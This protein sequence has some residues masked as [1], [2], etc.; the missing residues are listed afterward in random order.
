MR[1][2]ILGGVLGGGMPLRQDAIAKR[3]QV[4]QV[5]ARE[6]LRVLAEE[7]LVEVVPRK[8]A[9]VYSLT[10][11]EAAEITELRILLEGALLAAAIPN[12]TE[13]DL[14]AAEA[15]MHALDE[16]DGNAESLLRL[17]V[18]FHRALYSKAARP[19]TEAILERLRLNME[20]YLRL[21]W[22]RTGY[23]GKSQSE[24]AQILQLCRERR[25]EDVQ[26]VLRTHIESTG[27]EIQSL[28]E[29]NAKA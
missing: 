12:L 6:A 4:S 18:N 28:L 17:N 27:R 19:R 9:V 15:A 24:H 2:A 14:Q 26:R 1:E 16:S 11:S 22:N 21:L 23:L 8:G 20:P 25:I 7:G 3:F 29:A 13:D 5:T 10:P